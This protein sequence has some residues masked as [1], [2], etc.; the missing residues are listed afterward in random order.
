VRAYPV[1]TLTWTPTSG[2]DRAD[3]LLAELDGVGATA[4]E[5]IP[6]GLRV[7]FATTASRDAALTALRD[8]P[9]LT[10]IGSEVPDDDWAA[11]SQAALGP[12]TVGG[13]TVAPPWTVTPELRS[14]AP[15]LV[16]IQPSMGFGTGHHASTRLVLGWL[17]NVKIDG[18]AVLDVG[19]GSGV[20]AIAALQL[21]AAVSVA[22]DVDPDALASA[23]ENAELNGV[24][25]RIEIREISLSAAAAALGP[26]FH[27]ILANLTGGLLSRDAGSFRALAA[28]GASLIAS[29][30]QSPET[31]QIIGA[32]RDAGWTPAGEAHEQDWVGIRLLRTSNF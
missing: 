29:G 17:Q 10:C 9:D 8:L 4:I 14:H 30:F 23:R 1:L 22:I 28:P 7:H 26:R 5:D 18:L 13:I 15:R 11:R 16:V 12:I 21:G 20:L 19:T 3:S 2:V 27:V 31:P 25:S 24:A 32:F 6:N